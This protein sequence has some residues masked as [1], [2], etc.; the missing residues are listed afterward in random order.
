MLFL[1]PFLSLFFFF[2]V[3]FSSLSLLKEGDSAV[4][5]GMVGTEIRQGRRSPV[6]GRVRLGACTEEEADVALLGFVDLVEA[7]D[8][9]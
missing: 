6:V 1:L 3:R 4:M 9:R 5:V 2:F 8:L 7:E